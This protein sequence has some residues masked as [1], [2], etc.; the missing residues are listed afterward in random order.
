MILSKSQYLLGKLVNDMGRSE[1][2]LVMSHLRC[3]KIN[4]FHGTCDRCKI[5]TSREKI[6]HEFHSATSKLPTQ[7]TLPNIFSSCLG[8]LGLANPHQFY[9][10]FFV[11][12]PKFALVSSEGS[13]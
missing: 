4:I 1:G 8:A 12:L 10:I 2:E 11:S 6:N 9:F 3:S 5:N 13:D 7:P